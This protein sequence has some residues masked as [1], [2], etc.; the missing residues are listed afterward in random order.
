MSPL[1]KE[2][3]KIADAVRIE[4]LVWTAG[5]RSRPFTWDLNEEAA[6]NGEREGSGGRGETDGGVRIR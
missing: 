1:S 3:V 6:R 2:A 4:D 5:A